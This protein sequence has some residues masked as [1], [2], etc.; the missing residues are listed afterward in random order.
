MIK[1]KFNNFFISDD[2]LLFGKH[3]KILIQALDSWNVAMVSIERELISSLKISIYVLFI[4]HVWSCT[5]FV[6]SSSSHDPYVLNSKIPI[7]QYVWF[8]TFATHYILKVLNNQNH[9]DICWHMH[10]LIH[11]KVIN[12][13]RQLG[14]ENGRFRHNR[15]ASNV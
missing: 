12:K 2:H 3:N 4:L 8:W 15:Q 1:T 5:Q 7:S 6:S 10:V 11:N 9:L 14:G 13:V